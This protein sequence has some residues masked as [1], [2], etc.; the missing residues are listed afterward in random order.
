MNLISKFSDSELLIKTK[1]LASEEKR[2]AQEVINHL[3][4]IE[5][6]KLYLSLGY[7]SL[8]DYAVHELHYSGSSAYRRIAAMKVFKVLPEAKEKFSSGTVN[9]STLSQLQTFIN[10]EEKTKDCSREM[11]LDLLEKIENKSQDEC[12]REFV[13]ISPEF[14]KFK[15]KERVLT[16]EHT[17]DVSYSKG[18]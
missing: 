8:H 13:K 9:L 16:D 15:E 2:I 6:R 17:N 12:E 4:E 18:A 11:K 14:I 5:Y 1:N 7:S 3:E 10:K